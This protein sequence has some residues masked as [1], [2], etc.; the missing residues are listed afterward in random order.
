MYLDELGES[1]ERSLG[2][3]I[4]KLVVEPSERA[5]EK[6]RQL[7]SQARQEL[8]DA[9]FQR[10]VLELIETIVVYKLQ[11]LNR[12]EIEAMLGLGDFTKTRFY[13]EA[14]Q[15]GEQHTKVKT[16]ERM[17]QRGYSLQQIADVLDMPVEE[18]RKVAE[19]S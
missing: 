10:E 5:G 17:L 12:Q 1:A 2:L 15:E 7:V 19:E 9:V 13:Q 4:V 6:A 11:Q 16:M 3:G 14:F 8:A 18:V